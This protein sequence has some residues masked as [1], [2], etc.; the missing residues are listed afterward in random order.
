MRQVAHFAIHGSSYHA[1]LEHSH[2][3]AMGLAKALNR[4][5][6]TAY[7]P[8]ERQCRTTDVQRY[9]DIDDL[10]Y[11]IVAG[12]HSEIHHVIEGRYSHLTNGF[13]RTLALLRWLREIVARLPRAFRPWNAKCALEGLQ[14]VAPFL[15]AAVITWLASMAFSISQST[16]GVPLFVTPFVLLPAAYGAF[17]IARA[18]YDAVLR[19]RVQGIA[20]ALRMP[21]IVSGLNQYDKVTS[22]NGMSGILIAQA[23]CGLFAGVLLAAPLL[24]LAR[25][26]AGGPSGMFAHVSFPSIGLA[27]LVLYLSRLILQIVWR[28]A[29]IAEDVYTVGDLNRLS[30]VNERREEAIKAVARRLVALIQ[31][32]IAN[33]NDPYYDSI[34]VYGHSLGGII[35]SDVLAEIHRAVEA[36]V[37][38]VEDACRIKTVVTYGSAQEKILRHLRLNTF[39]RNPFDRYRSNVPR[40]FCGDASERRYDARWF[41]VYYQFDIV[42]EEVTGYSCCKNLRLRSPN[43]D[44]HTAYLRDYLFFDLVVDI[45]VNVSVARYVVRQPF[46]KQIETAIRR[47]GI[48]ISAGFIRA[49]IGLSSLCALLF[50]AAGVALAHPLRAWLPLG[51]VLPSMNAIWCVIDDRQPPILLRRKV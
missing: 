5:D 13:V 33:T 37:I 25:I 39:V 26:A 11:E 43:I 10:I 7:R 22:G 45:A 31:L 2:E 16:L 30:A 8:V 6:C 23:F 17:L 49:S 15:G 51:L 4:R 1:R 18:M 27:M 36:G 28:T 20:S 24:L 14:I 46:V 35:A 38:T 21:D 3:F 32:R 9:D 41:N 29:G 12:K 50:T 48:P 47:F 19:E 34:H 42:A 44:P 40:L